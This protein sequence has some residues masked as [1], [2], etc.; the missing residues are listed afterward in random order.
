MTPPWPVGSS[1]AVVGFGLIGGSVGLGAREL[2]RARR[3]VGIDVLEV[4]RSPRARA[5]ADDLVDI[6]DSERVRE[7]VGVADLVVLAAPVKAIEAHL[8]ELGPSADLLTDCGSTKRSV[9]EAARR[10]GVAERFVAGHPMAGDP[11]GGV[12]HARADLFRGR[13]WILCPGDAT[14]DRLVRIEQF[15]AMLGAQ[16]R[17]LDAAR[18]DAAVALTSHVP[19]LLASALYAFAMERGAGVAAGPAFD[20]ATRVAGGSQVMWRDILDTNAD[21]IAATI[22]ELS[23]RLHAVARGLEQRPPDLGPAL[24]LID[25][26]RGAKRGSS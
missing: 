19:Q 10:F 4:I 26:A 1:V 22:R 20:S 15:V 2:A 3:V 17:R 8:G 13:P 18:H 14:E 9:T 6:A 12:D 25:Q 11:R 23:G 7:Q 5:I 24:D 16:P 21:E